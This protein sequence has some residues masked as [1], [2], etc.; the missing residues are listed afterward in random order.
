[1]DRHEHIGQGH[2]GIKAFELI[3]NDQRLMQI[4]KII[5]TPKRQAG[6]DYDQINLNLLR[7]LV[8]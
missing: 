6:K 3:M 7:G 4:P 2:I 5:E 8:I 1:V